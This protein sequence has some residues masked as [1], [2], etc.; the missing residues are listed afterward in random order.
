MSEFIRLIHGIRFVTC[1][2]QSSDYTK[3]CSI[4][5]IC[6]RSNFKIKCICIY[7]WMFIQMYLNDWDTADKNTTT[8]ADTHGAERI[9][10]RSPD[11]HNK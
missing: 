6:G 1:N 5:A 4:V 9:S 11:K 8:H 3:K 2:V 7:I 10:I